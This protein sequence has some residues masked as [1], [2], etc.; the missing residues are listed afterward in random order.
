VAA[1]PWNAVA[2]ADGTRP[3]VFP[4]RGTRAARSL[5]R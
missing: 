3:D 1:A 4:A 2:A 5:S